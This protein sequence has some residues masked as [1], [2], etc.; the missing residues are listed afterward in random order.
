MPLDRKDVEDLNESVID[1]NFASVE[2]D[3]IIDIVGDKSSYNKGLPVRNTLIIVD[4][5]HT[6]TMVDR[7]L[8]DAE[9]LRMYG[10]RI[11]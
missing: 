11:E 5:K 8:H 7:K 3:K 10:S 2:L 1:L 6:K 9:K 4:L